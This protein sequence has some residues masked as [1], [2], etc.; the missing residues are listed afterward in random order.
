VFVGLAL[1]S[2]LFSQAE[3]LILSLTRNETQ[4]GYYSAALKLVTLWS[5]IPASYMTVVFPIL[6]IAYQESRQKAINIQNKSIKYLLALALPLAV[7]MTVLA[8]RIILQVYGPRFEES[9][10]ALRLLSWYVPLIFCNEVLWR[11]LLARDEQHLVLRGQLIADVLRTSIALLL[12]PRLGYRGAVWAL[13]GGH[14]TYA[15]YHTYYVQR[16]GT[17]LPLVELGWRFVLA[18]LVMGIFAW[19]CAQWVHLSVLIPLAAV[20]YVALIVGLRAFSQDDLALFWQM[21]KRPRVDL[22]ATQEA[23]IID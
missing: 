20:V 14:L 10:W 23:V 5:M 8:D 13:I 6:T 1:L 17:R 2:T 9:S 18:S 12:T 21:L 3:I 7:G 22:A 11:I 16:G 15:I 4:V 19:I